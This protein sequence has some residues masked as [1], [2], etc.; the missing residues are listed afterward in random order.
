VRS[1][2]GATQTLQRAT[3]C[4]S[5]YVY[6]LWGGAVSWQ[7][8]RQPSVALAT[9]D[10]EYIGLAQAARE[11]VWLRQ[12]LNELGSTQQNATLLYGNNRASLALAQNP[13]PHSRSKEIDIRYHFL[14]ELVERGVIITKYTPTASMIADGFGP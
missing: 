13:M 11:A 4:T 9:G 3:L 10:A 6:T 7:S 2:G 8:K 5:G 14:R 1:R 12:L